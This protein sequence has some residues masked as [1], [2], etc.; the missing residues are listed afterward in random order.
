MRTIIVA[1]LVFCS[2]E[3]LAQHPQV[4]TG[5]WIGFGFGYGSA[6]VSCDGCAN[7]D[8]Q[9]AATGFLKMGGTLNDRILLGG[10]I[11][12]WTKASGAVETTVGNTS[13]AVYFYPKPAAGW[14]VR[15]GVGHALAV[16]DNA[17]GGGNA[18]ATGFG[19]V[20]GGGYDIRVGRNISITP[21]LNFYLGAD[22]DLEDHGTT[23]ETGMKHNV[24]EFGLG[25]TFH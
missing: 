15:G 4:R 19:F 20:V 2:S 16:V 1:L 14:F 8:R 18:Q 24:L 23:V 10:E 9:A 6:A 25:L 3:A 21:V 7:A 5:F 22:G 13:F 11:N 12:V 17:I